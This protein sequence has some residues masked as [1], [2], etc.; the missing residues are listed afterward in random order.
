MSGYEQPFITAL[1]GT[2]VEYFETIVIAYAIIRAGHPREAVSAT[3]AG[4][5]LVFIGAVFL[6]PLHEWIPVF[7]FRLVA[8]LML[9]LMGGW[10]TLKSTRRLIAHQRPRWVDDPLGKVGLDVSDAVTAAFSW[11]VFLIMLKSSVIE[12]FEILLVVFP[13]AASTAAW[14]PVLAGAATGIII[15]TLAAWLLHGQL[16]RIP[17]V[18]V[19]LT[20]GLLLLL[21]GLSWLNELR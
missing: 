14:P 5:V 9:T 16:K 21:I 3:A 13:L 12:A 15:V 17:E 2:S 6:W 19:K 1:L 18:K 4:H 10:W 11:L 8:A 7:A 20:T